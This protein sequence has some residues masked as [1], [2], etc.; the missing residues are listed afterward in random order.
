V[1]NPKD[2]IES[3]IKVTK[4]IKEELAGEDISYYPI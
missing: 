2:I 3:T 4:M 1:N